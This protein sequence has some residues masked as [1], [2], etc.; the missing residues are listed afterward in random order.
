M[1][2]LKLVV[3]KFEDDSTQSV[4]YGYKAR[5]LNDEGERDE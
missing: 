1:S 3:L 5:L 2:Y 4:A